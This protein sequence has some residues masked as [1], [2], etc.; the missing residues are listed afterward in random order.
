MLNQSMYSATAISRSLM[1]RHGPRLRTRF[2]LVN[3]SNS[4][5]PRPICIFRFSCPGPR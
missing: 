5:G 3:A 4:L 1:L 2:G